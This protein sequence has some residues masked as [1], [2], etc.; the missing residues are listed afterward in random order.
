VGEGGHVF[1]SYRSIERPFALKLA[2]ALRN[3]GVRL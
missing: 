3:A 1:L 2:A